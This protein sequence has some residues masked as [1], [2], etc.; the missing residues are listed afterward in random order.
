MIIS[1][2][3]MNAGQMVMFNGPM[4]ELRGGRVTHN[5]WD[6]FCIDE[7]RGGDPTDFSHTNIGTLIDGDM[8]HGHVTIMEVE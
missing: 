1:T 7:M 4:G 2:R 3:E 5:E 6:F 8:V